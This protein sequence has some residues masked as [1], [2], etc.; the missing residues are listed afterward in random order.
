MASSDIQ[1]NV[2]DNC[3]KLTH[4]ASEVLHDHSH[5]DLTERVQL[6]DE[7]I[8]GV[9]GCADVYYGRLVDSG[10]YVAVKRLRVHIEKEVQLSKA[11]NVYFHCL[12]CPSNEF[13]RT[14]LESLG[15]GLFSVTPTSSLCLDT[16]F[17][18][19]VRL[20]S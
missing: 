1:S 16:H 17:T 6:V 19:E 4:A 10:K 8:R 18:E 13:G 2:Y 12:I 14:S 3:F 5:L 15:Y 7:S 20:H 11:F 9:G